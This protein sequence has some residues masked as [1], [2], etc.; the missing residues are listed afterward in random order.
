MSKS[1][2][3]IGDKQRDTE[4]KLAIA[5]N[6]GAIEYEFTGKVQLAKEYFMKAVSIS[7][8]LYGGEDAKTL[9]FNNRLQDLKIKV[10]RQRPDFIKSFNSTMG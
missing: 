4:F 10:E 7:E 2:Q 8:R 9:M 3:P 1:E 5:Y 6:N